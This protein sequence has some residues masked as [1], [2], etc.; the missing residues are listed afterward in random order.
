MDIL[1]CSY[2]YAPE[3]GTIP[4]VSRLLADE[5]TRAG[6]QVTLLT[7]IT[8]PEGTDDASPFPVVRR[9]SPLRILALG[10][11]ADVIHFNNISL[12]LLL[13]L[14]FLF[15]PIVITHQEWLSRYHGGI[16]WQDRIK[17]LILHLV[18]NVAV[19]Q[20][21]AHLLPAK[22]EVIGNPFDRTEFLPGHD[23]PRQRDIVYIG[24]LTREKGCDIA[25]LAIAQLAGQGIDAT[26]TI[27]GDGL[28][29]EYLEALAASQNIAS[30]V[31]FLGHITDG[32]G[33]I[34]AQHTVLVVPSRRSEPFG[35]VA[36]EGIAA[37]CVVVA[38][39]SGGLPEA[40]GPCGF[41]FPAG[42]VP[43]LAAALKQALTDNKARA[44]IISA[45]PAHLENFNPAKIARLYLNIFESL[46]N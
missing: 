30:Q 3:V 29:R 10:L 17:R 23:S 8:A 26:F 13:P 1:L 22:S 42:N 39:S 28:E 16:G 25:I 20:P 38:S 27:V 15:K 33:K 37:G 9:P 45:G 4:T 44:A 21:I 11:H 18:K 6:H 2:H 43:A 5:Y 34:L 36:L 35:V 32:L 40:V 46:L 31:S 12:R 19:S 24:R 7:Y 14:F 41:L